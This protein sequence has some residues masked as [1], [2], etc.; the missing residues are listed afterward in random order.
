MGSKI[1]VAIYLRVSTQDQNCDLQ[2][3]DLLQ[4]TNSREWNVFQVYEDKAT[5]TNS[6]RSSLKQMLQDA[7]H[8]RFDVL[9]CWKLDR[10]AR[11]LKDLVTIIQELTELGVSFVALKD[12]V[13]L[14]TSAGRLMLHIIGSFAQFEADI[15]KERVRSGLD[16][17]RRKGTR[18]GRPPQV[19]LN[20]VL[21][22]Q[23]RGFSLGRIAKQIG[24]SKSAVWQAVK[25][26]S[27]RK[28]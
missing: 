16:A 23:E 1:K 4:Y 22:L 13:D 20:K 3:E 11:S 2:R 5:G 26:C 19:S 6:N 14:T 9:I 8:R 21:E 17:A 27:E 18:L 10:I 12:S 15:I 25:K 24:V 28:R 7:R